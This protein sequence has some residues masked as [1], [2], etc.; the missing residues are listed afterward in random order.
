MMA[1]N[2]E[3]RYAVPAE[4]IGDLV[5]LA[6]QIGL[7][8][9]RRASRLWVVP[10]ERPLSFV[11]RHVPWVAAVAALIGIVVLLD[12]SSAPRDEHLPAP[13]TVAPAAPGT[14]V[15]SS[16]G[17]SRPSAKQPSEGLAMSASPLVRPDDRTT[18]PRDVAVAHDRTGGPPHIATGPDGTAVA[19]AGA[20]SPSRGIA[21]GAAE[22]QDDSWESPA[23]GFS[24]EFGA[25]MEQPDVLVV[26]NSP[27]GHNEFS[28][29]AGACAAAHSGDTIELRFDG[30]R[31]ERPIPISNL[32]LTIRA[33]EGF[34]PVVV[35]W[36]TDANPIKQPRSMMTLASGQ[37]AMFDVAL[38]LRIPRGVPADSWSLL[39]T[40]GGQMVHM[41]RCTLTT[42]NA[43]DQGSTYHQDVAFLRARSAPNADLMMDAVRAATPLATV[44]LVDCIARG[45][46]DLLRVDDP[47]PV[48]LTW[49]NGL[50]IT[51]ERLLTTNGSQWTPKPDE[52]RIE[53]R[54]VTAAVGSGLCRL[55]SGPSNP[56]QLA[57]Q[58]VSTN[59]I[60]IA[61]P[62]VPLIEQQGASSIEDFRRLFVW[63]GDRNFYEGVDVFWSVSTL[64]PE[65]S[66]DVMN[67]EAWK[68]YW[69]PC[70]KISPARNGC[71]GNGRPIRASRCTV[72]ASAIIL[73]KTR[74]LAIPRQ[75]RPAAASIGCRRYQRNRHPNGQA[76]RC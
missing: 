7:Q 47:Q 27:D 41:E 11:Q 55:T 46:A 8:P 21:P 20:A 75:A 15:A 67:F 76:R 38:E 73:S 49:D 2:R 34:R 61:P 12:F 3:D 69:G 68:T 45:E 28:T 44:E 17:P 74:P 58:F 54:H 39:E 65:D 24:D 35:F 42:S 52:M 31:L 14:P 56:H 33:A 32:N 48:S 1:K 70:A 5:R 18:G 36:P 59:S 63:N 29:L 13:A 16:N 50:L 26:T 37:L 9:A 66:S 4:L 10:Q 6:E 43:T 60:L 25:A 64:D 40:E 72:R 30:P 71:C 51:T 19:S 22:S 57:V 53:L 62:G 23:P